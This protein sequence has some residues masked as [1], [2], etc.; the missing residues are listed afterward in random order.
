M[1]ALIPS[2]GGPI[3]NHTRRSGVF[4]QP[5]PWAILVGAVLFAL[6]YLRHLPCI[7]TEPANP[8]NAYIRLCYSDVMT[9]YSYLGWASGVQLVGGEQLTLAPLLGVLVTFSG[10]FANLLGWRIDDPAT[11]NPY[12]GLAEFFGANAILLFAAFLLLIVCSATLARRAGRPWDVLL[13]AASPVAFAAGL[14]NWDLLP[15]ALTALALVAFGAN[16][17]LEAA[18][19]LGLAASAGTMPLVFAAAM[20]AFL[21]LRDEWRRCAVFVGISAATFM[22]VAL[23]Q[24]LASFTSL[25]RYYHGIINTEISY[26]SVWYLL[27]DMQVPLRE[28]GGFT[29]VVS[30][31]VI[32]VMLAWLYTSGRTVALE[33]LIAMMVLVIV[34]LAPAYPP[35][36]ALWVLFALFLVRPADPVVWGFSVLQLLHTAAVWGRLAGHLEPGGNGPWMLYHLVVA[37]RIG[38]EAAFLAQTVRSMRRQPCRLHPPV[39]AGAATGTVAVG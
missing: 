26:G 14:I 20:I 12:D 1:N 24:A 25:Y 19:V 39:A 5:L 21:V 35:Q 7:T 31:L 17:T 3:G 9:N 30:L 27:L 6:L 28:F 34:L 16:R 10:W 23:P 11:E 38:F 8:V 2:L 18:I 13:V 29:F 22:L 36:M 15:L 37:L 32:G 33:Q 4:F